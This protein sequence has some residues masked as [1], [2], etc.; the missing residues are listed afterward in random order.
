MS[1]GQKSSHPSQPG[2]FL[3]LGAFLVLSLFSF[4]I[5]VDPDIGGLRCDLNRPTTKYGSGLVSPT[6]VQLEPY[7][8]LLACWSC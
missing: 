8:Y 2:F 6:L 1:P 5:L 7:P 3:G 4:E